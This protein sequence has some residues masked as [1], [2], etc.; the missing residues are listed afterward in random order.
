MIY[1][2]YN[3]N[4]L[5]IRNTFL[6]LSI[7]FVSLYPVY[8]CPV[9]LYPVGV[10]KKSRILSPMEKKVIAYH[11]AGHALMGWLLQHTDLLLKV[12]LVIMYHCVSYYLAFEIYSVFYALYYHVLRPLSSYS[13]SSDL[14]FCVL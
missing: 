7:L 12:V 13:T 1:I 4:T 3:N 5:Y 2:Y 14:M 6:F 8:S 10:A 9:Y 11:E